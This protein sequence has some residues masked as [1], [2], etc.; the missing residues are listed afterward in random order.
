MRQR[1]GATDGMPAR[2]LALSVV[3]SVTENGAYASLAL[4]EKLHG[5]TLSQA[6]RRLVARLAYDT[7]D[8]LI[9]LDWALAKVMAK[10][11]TDIRLRNILRLAACQ[12]LL[13]D[14][15]PDMAATDT[16]VRLCVELE[17]PGLKGV[18]NGILRSLVRLRDAG[19]LR[20]PED[21]SP[22]ALSLRLSTPR[23]LIE[24]LLADWDPETL[25]GLLGRQAHLDYLVLR[26]NLLRLKEDEFDALLEKKVWEVQPGLVPFTRRVTGAVDISADNDFNGGL[27]S[28]QS[29]GSVLAVLAMDVRRGMKVLDCC[30]APGGKSCLMSE[31]MGDT[32]RVMAWDVKE[33]RV[34]LIRAQQ[35]RLHLENIRP[36]ARDASAHRDDLD[37]TMDAVLLDAPCS[38]T[39]DLADKP[40]LKLRL[41]PESIDSLIRTQAELLDAVCP[42]VREGGTLVYSTCSVLKDENERQ[43]SAFLLRHPE[44]ELS[45]LPET[46]PERFRRY[47]STGLQLLPHRDGLNGFY[48]ARLRRKRL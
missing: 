8:N 13:E 4:D 18:C 16:A 33:H 40:D 21:G 28:I 12:L 29:E 39:G 19:E 36:V 3:R 44:F 7:I 46:I 20:L 14:R 48:L 31:L 42:Y 38:G 23:W 2:R 32:G 43:I 1:P 30:A 9:Y 25:R 27:F 22:E 41:T 47:E 11:D 37:Q 24:R 45:P 5:C 35:Q 34:A 17:M 10:P 26:P 15:I 6:D